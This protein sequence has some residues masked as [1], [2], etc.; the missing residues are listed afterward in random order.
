MPNARA[1][2]TPLSHSDEGIEIAQDDIRIP[3]NNAVRCAGHMTDDRTLML[4]SR[5]ER[6]FAL[7]LLTA[8]TVLVPTC[9][10]WSCAFDWTVL[11]A[12]PT[13]EPGVA[14]PDTTMGEDTPPA[15]VSVAGDGAPADASDDADATSDAWDADGAGPCSV[16]SPCGEGE[17]C[18]FTDHYCGS[19]MTNGT[20]VAK[21]A[22]CGDAGIKPVCGCDHKVYSS[23]CAAEDEGEDVS[24][25]ACST[26]PPSAYQCG[27]RFCSSGDFCA[28]NGTGANATYDCMP[29]SG[30]VLGCLCTQ[31]LLKCLGGTCSTEDGHVI[32]RCP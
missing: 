11:A 2:V 15:D 7:R 14:S 9:L 5:A 16:S 13:E 10:L 28:I 31:A 18:R 19:G 22:H 17:L 32:T 6:T 25:Q 29:L 12:R 1:R 20:C 24:L 4:F 21:P 30:C 27:Y 23:R 3:T 8:T 26:T